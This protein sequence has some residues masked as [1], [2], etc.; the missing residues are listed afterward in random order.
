METSPIFLPL[1]HY[2][3]TF[4]AC[5]NLT[6]AALIASVPLALVVAM[7]LGRCRSRT[8]LTVVGAWCAILILYF[9]GVRIYILSKPGGYWCR[10]ACIDNLRQID[11]A[12]EQWTSEQSP[13]GDRLKALPE[14]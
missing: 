6:W 13:A 14:E 2:V 3:T 8:L 11:A 7:V 10:K 4:E 5:P 1:A 12:K 9:V